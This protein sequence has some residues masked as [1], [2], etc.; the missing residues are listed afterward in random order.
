MFTEDRL[1]AHVYWRRTLPKQWMTLKHTLKYII[2]C[3]IAKFFLVKID[4]VQGINTNFSFR[5]GKNVLKLPRNDQTNVRRK[6]IIP[7]RGAFEWFGRFRNG[8][9][10][11]EYEEHAW[12]MHS[13]CVHQKQLRKTVSMRRRTTDWLFEYPPTFKGEDYTNFYNMG[14]Y[15]TL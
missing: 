14:D 3:S 8:L 9:E 15:V 10:Y 4:I 1:S 2:S 7:F 12:W 13:M 6:S 11:V 5:L